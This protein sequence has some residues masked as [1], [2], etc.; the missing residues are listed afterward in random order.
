MANNN[1]RF[2]WA[3]EDV[4]WRDNYR[5]RPYAAS[6]ERNYDYFQPAYRFGFESAAR[7]PSRNWEDVE[8]DLSRG[9]NTYEHRGSSTWEQMKGAVRDAWNRITAKEPAPAH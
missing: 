3:D 5:T 2:N 6:G 9:W 1:T 7:Y 4:Y 8:S